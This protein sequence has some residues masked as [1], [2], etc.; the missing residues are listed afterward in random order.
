MRSLSLSTV[1]QGLRLGKKALRRLL[2][3]QPPLGRSV[4]APAGGATEA[5]YGAGGQKESYGLAAGPAEPYGA[6]RR[7]DWTRPSQQFGIDIAENAA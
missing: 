1:L 6:P 2:L 3:P 5:V 7:T 4:Y